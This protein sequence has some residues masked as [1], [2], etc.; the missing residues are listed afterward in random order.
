MLFVSGD[1]SID[2]ESREFLFIINLDIEGSS[3]QFSHKTKLDPP[4]GNSI[5]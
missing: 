2:G 4:L 1:A 5:V 3:S